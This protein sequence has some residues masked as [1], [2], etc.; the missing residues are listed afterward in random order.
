MPALIADASAERDQRVDQAEL[1]KRPGSQLQRDPTNV[2][3]GLLD[4]LGQLGE[5][6][7][8]AAGPLRSCSARSATAVSVWPIS[9][10]SSRAIRRRSSSWAARRAPRA[11]APL[12]LQAIEHL[13]ERLRQRDRLAT[14]ASELRSTAPRGHRI[15]DGHQPCQAAQRLDHPPHECDVRDQHHDQSA[16]HDCKLIKPDRGMDRH[17]RKRQQQRR[18][19]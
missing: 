16:N 17:R 1:V 15:H 8:L 3:E 6:G 4:D 2:R 19:R 5:L 18:G 11:L 13:V 7:V 10:W 9:S 12:G 14:G